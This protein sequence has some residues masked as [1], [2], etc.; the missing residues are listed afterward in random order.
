[1]IRRL[2][3]ALVLLAMC[4]GVGSAHAGAKLYRWKDSNGNVVMSDRPPPAGVQ[5]EAISTSSSLVHS[6][7]SE[8]P[9]TPPAP[10][11]PAA[12][13]REASTLP[14]PSK[15]I[16]KKNPE[17]CQTARQNLEVLDRAPRIRMPDANG[18]LH[19]LTDEERE[20]ERQKNLDI[21]AA[22]CD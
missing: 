6:V 20:Q 11:H 16:Y 9:A 5:F 22:H 18:E 19:Y 2:G 21:I 1:M 17:Y 12:P 3:V 8:T 7:D 13:P 4:A 15:E 10:T 14:E